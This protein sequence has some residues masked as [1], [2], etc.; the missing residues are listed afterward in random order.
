MINNVK[1]ASL[2]RTLIAILYIALI[3]QEKKGF[4]AV[5]QILNSNFFQNPA[6]LSLVKKMNLIIGNIFITPKFKFIGMAYG[7]TGS[8]VSKVQN[9]LPY[10]LGDYRF[11][12]KFVLGVN[13][14]P[15][16][17]GHLQWPFDSIVIYDSTTTKLVYYRIGVQTSY[18]FT[19]KLALGAGINLQYNKLGE[20]DA[21]IPGKGNQINKVSALNYTIDGG[22]YYKIN[23]RNFLTAAFY[24][25]VHRPGHGTSTMADTTVYNLFMTVTEGPV[26]YIGFQHQV[27]EKLFLEEKV[28]WSGWSIQ[29]YLFFTNTTT[30][31]RVAPTLWKDTFS[32]QISTR[33]AIDEKVALLGSLMY[34]TNPGGPVVTNSI[35]YPLA[36]TGAVSTGLDYSFLKNFS[37]QLLYGYGSFI[38]NAKINNAN[39][40]GIVTANSQAVV[41]QLTCKV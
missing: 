6:E 37:V 19:E 18:Q 25:A 33:Y 13:M 5:D 16:G 36:A 38:P 3:I 29:K 32:F 39:D 27:T 23:S 9:S 4:T 21:V 2:K 34:E 12:D 15:S 30:G 24:S 31:N 28:Y 7:N 26:A 11:T 8:A 35:G 40:K 1:T 14:T 20:L 41:L 22:V 10:L 17:Y